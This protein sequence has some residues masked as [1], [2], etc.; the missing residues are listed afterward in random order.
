[1]TSNNG[2]QCSGAVGGSGEPIVRPKGSYASKQKRFGAA[3]LASFEDLPSDDQIS[4]DD[5][6][7]DNDEEFVCDPLDGHPTVLDL[8]SSQLLMQNRRSDN[9]NTSPALSPTLTITPTSGGGGGERKASYSL[10]QNTLTDDG[11]SGSV[12]PV[13]ASG[14]G[15]GNS[16]S[17]LSIGSQHRPATGGSHGSLLTVPDGADGSKSPT[18]PDSKR[19]S[20]WTDIF[21]AGRGGRTRSK[22]TSSSPRKSPTTSGERKKSVFAKFISFGRKS[23]SRTSI[24]ADTT[25][26]SGEQSSAIELSS[27]GGGVDTPRVS[28]TDT[29]ENEPNEELMIGS[30]INEPEASEQDIIGIIEAAASNQLM[31]ST[32]VD[33]SGPDAEPSLISVPLPPLNLR[34]KLKRRQ[35]TIDDDVQSLPEIL[36]SSRSNRQLISQNLA[37]NNN[38]SHNNN[39]NNTETVVV[40]IESSA[41]YEDNSSESEIG[42]DESKL[43]ANNNTNNN[44]ES[45]QSNGKSL[46][47]SEDDFEAQNLLLS[48]TQE[49]YDESSNSSEQQLFGSTNL[50]LLSPTTASA[51]AACQLIESIRSP[52]RKERL[53]VLTIPIERPRSTTPIN[54]VPL[55]AYISS[56]CTSPDPSVE[57][58]KLSLPGEQFTASA[59]AKSPRKSNPSIWFEFCEKGLQS[60]LQRRKQRANSCFPSVDSTTSPQQQLQPNT[61]SFLNNNSNFDAFSSSVVSVNNPLTLSPS[62]GNLTPVTPLEGY[63]GD[64]K[65]PGFGDNFVNYDTF[66]SNNFTDGG[67]GGGLG[68]DKFLCKCECNTNNNTNNSSAN[69]CAVDE[70]QQQPDQQ[71]LLQQQQ[72]Q[73]VSASNEMMMSFSIGDEQCF[74]NNNNNKSSIASSN[75]TTT[76]STNRDHEFMEDQPLVSPCHCLCHRRADFALTLWRSSSFNKQES[77]SS[78]ISSASSRLIGSSSHSSKCSPSDDIIESINS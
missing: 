43:K 58:I 67:G 39:D 66:F 46:S 18:T 60:P 15:V 26:Q 64:T 40:Q 65:W 50:S 23:P 62:P 35:S 76:T 19:K 69:T 13:A 5:D 42:F 72:Q 36:P 78:D 53:E 4:P 34:K 70:Q 38:D 8:D 77:V 56:S 55:E 71:I 22:S 29:S 63:G 27:T 49:D 31:I 48:S 51:A 47:E 11:G 3:P 30:P 44:K 21:F 7:D 28:V 68:V 17:L 12:T 10:S 45:K 61:P 6:D 75:N 20:S 73:P 33:A 16:E 14:G 1:M 41:K 52:T 32:P 2:Q 25:T 9:S 24:S 57:K 74:N 54:I 59:R 37:N